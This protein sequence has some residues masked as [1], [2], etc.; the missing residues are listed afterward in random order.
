MYAAVEGLP[1]LGKSEVLALLRLYFPNLLVL[2]E[3]V[4]EVVEREGLDPWRDRGKLTEAL[5]AALPR[6][7]AQIR[8]ALEQGRMVLEDSHLGVHAA[9]CAALDDQG[10]LEAFAR[11]EPDLLWP[12][13]FVRFDAPLEVSLARQEARGDP[14]FFV[15][16]E[17]LARMSGWLAAWHARRGDRVVTV[18]A[19]RSPAEVL[20]DVLHALEL[21]YAPQPA[22]EVL[23]YLVLL[24]RPAAGKTELIQFLQGLPAAERARA[25]HLGALR[26]LDDF[27]ILWEKFVEDDVWERLGRGRLHSR[28]C[29]ENYAVADPLLWDFLLHRLGARIAAAPARPGETVVVEFSRGGPGAYAHALPLLPPP[30]WAEGAIL[31]L[32]VS[33]EESLR[34]NRARYDRDR[35]DGLLTHAVPEEEMARTYREDDWEELAPKEAG[36]LTLGG[37]RVPYVRVRN[38]PEPK[39]LGDFARRFRPALEELFELWKNR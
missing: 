9:Y 1:A 34:R 2:P 27:P 30:V 20:A 25:Y 38:E 16:G 3:L 35:R 31:Y 36:Y 39:G 13:L 17:V 29:A 18:P 12:A 22:P 28:R 19:D 23:P 14:R 10:F 24:G 15:P 4:R 26:V 8:A 21:R 33:Y 37:H 5:L 32:S 6:R 11:L 7:Q